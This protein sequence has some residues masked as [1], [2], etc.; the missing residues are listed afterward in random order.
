LT[1]RRDTFTVPVLRL[2]R[3]T[4][5]AMLSAVKRSA[6]LPRPA[7]RSLQDASTAWL[8][9]LPEGRTIAQVR[10][11]LAAFAVVRWIGLAAVAL[12]GFL[13]P[14]LSHTALVAL[15]L[16]VAAYNGWLTWVLVRID[17]ARV[18]GIAHLTAVFD[19]V[20]CLVFLALYLSMNPQIG[21]YVVIMV[22]AVAYL[23]LRG[24]ILSTA[25]FLVVGLGLGWFDIYVY[26][27][28]FV[29]EIA[30]S[31]SVLILLAGTATAVADRVL[32][33]SLPLTTEAVH[34]SQPETTNGE[35]PVSETIRLSPRE[36][37]VLILVA[38]GHSNA[39]IA[40]QLH[41]SERTVKTHI[42][43]LLLRLK[44]RNRAG[45]VAEAARLRLL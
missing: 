18:V 36:Q 22:E 21:I 8:L 29:P 45:A 5:T 3:E 40:R 25:T 39:M 9:R 44:V 23:G 24:A 43:N 6:T 13:H 35:D 34:L 41:V 10:R 42:E 37:E 2:V 17:D 31:W 12:I 1:W 16:V 28:P 30:I 33:S 38:R 27:I 20:G 14:P 11:L 4:P 15:I 19:L 7:A 32:H 26:R